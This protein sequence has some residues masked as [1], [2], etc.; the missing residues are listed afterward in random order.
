MVNLIQQ[1][2]SFELHKPISIPILAL[3]SLRWMVRVDNKIVQTKIDC[4]FHIQLK[5]SVTKKKM[6]A[7]ITHENVST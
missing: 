1:K 7:Q 2:I 6:I 5:G 4:H 3:I